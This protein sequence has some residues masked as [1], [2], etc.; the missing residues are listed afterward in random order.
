VIS[1]VDDACAATG[2]E[3]GNATITT[4]AQTAIGESR[5]TT[6]PASAR[7]VETSVVRFDFMVISWLLVSVFRS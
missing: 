3:I 7:A 4:R 6:F 5:P 1:G 2:G